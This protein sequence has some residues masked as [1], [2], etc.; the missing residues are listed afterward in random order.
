MPATV[1]S[2]GICWFLINFFRSRL[3]PKSSFKLT[4]I[5]LIFHDIIL[6][7][8]IKDEGT[9]EVGMPTPS[10]T[11]QTNTIYHDINAHFFAN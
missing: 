1:K 8:A 11:P 10:L 6:D 4:P 5:H 3:E 2:S 9:T 7:N